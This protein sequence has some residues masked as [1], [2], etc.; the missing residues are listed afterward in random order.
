MNCFQVQHLR[1]KPFG[2]FV[3][4]EGCNLLH[5][6]RGLFPRSEAVGQ[7]LGQPAL[8]MGWSKLRQCALQLQLVLLRA[9]RRP[10]CFRCSRRVASRGLWHA[11]PVLRSSSCCE[12]A[13]RST[14]TDKFAFL[15]LF[16]ARRFPASLFPFLGIYSSF[17]SRAWAHPNLK[18]QRRSGCMPCCAASSSLLPPP[19]CPSSMRRKSLD[20]FPSAG[21]F[22]GHDRR[23]LSP[24]HLMRCEASV[25][26]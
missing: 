3:R 20:F 17:V 16:S 5:C 26:R 4:Q 13:P 24:D 6:L 1:T 14:A 11:S 18:R 2:R 12:P 10:R 23:M 19:H 21:A 25:S 9:L 15:D 22:F 8:S 7:H